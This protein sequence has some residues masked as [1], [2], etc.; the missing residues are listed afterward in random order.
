[1]RL[2]WQATLVL[3][4]VGFVLV[5]GLVLHRLLEEWRDRRHRPARE[6]LRRNLLSSLNAPAADERP[7]AAAM[8]P[9]DRLPIGETARLVDELAQIVRG[10]ARQRLAAF[11]SA[12]GVERHWLKRLRSR[13][14][15]YRIEA[16][17]C[18]ALLDTVE[19]RAALEACLAAGDGRLRLAAAEA[20]AHRPALA[21]G[22]AA[23]LFD[24]GAAEGRH[25]ARF[26]HRLAAV[27]PAVLLGRLDAAA[28]RPQ[29]LC[30]LV[31]ALG[32]ASHVAAAGRLEALVGR[33]DETVDR[34]VVLALHRLNHP[35]V[36]RVARRLAAGVQPETRRTALSVL[37]SQARAQDRD[38]VQS[39]AA[40]PV[41]DISAVAITVL[42]R[43]AAQ[44]ATGAQP[45]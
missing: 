37:A 38:L 7:T 28:G 33:E 1:M 21:N 13:L 19:S 32:D 27:A 4:A 8:A 25:A 11:A 30:R 39:L 17:R 20:L 3:V 23:R 45:A 15:P 41:A 2:I 44:A 43:L 40:D 10:D 35:A 24:D 36:V 34:A 14:G 6:R 18:L 9:P 22:L 42:S 16:A 5:S 26:W 31:E 29:L 12:N